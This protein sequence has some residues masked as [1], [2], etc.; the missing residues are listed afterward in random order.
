MKRVPIFIL[1]FFLLYGISLAAPGSVEQ[2]VN[3]FYDS[4]EK[5]D[6]TSFLSSLTSDKA[7][8]IKNDSSQGGNLGIIYDNLKEMRSNKVL[9]KF[10]KRKIEVLSQIDNYINVKVDVEVKITYPDGT[11][12]EVS[13]TDGFSLKKVNNIWLIEDIR[14]IKEDQQK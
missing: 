8:T 5:T 9:Y 10:I 12:E 6:E 3:T 11:K 7:K 2:T 1:I 13:G 14:K 4:V